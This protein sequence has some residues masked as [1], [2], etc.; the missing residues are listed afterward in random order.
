MARECGDGKTAEKLDTLYENRRQSFDGNGMM[1]ADSQYYEGN[2]WN[3]SF[4]L[5]HDMDARIELCGT[6]EEFAQR[7]DRFFGFT[8]GNDKTAR[9]EGYNNETDMETPY[10]YHYCGRRDRMCEVL[11]AGMKYMFTEG[12]GGIPGNNDSGA[13]SSC[14]VWNALGIFPVSGQ[15]LMLIGAP[16]IKKAVL[17]LWNGRDFTIINES[18]DVSTK[19]ELCGIPLPGMTL[20]VRQMM[21]GG[22]III[23]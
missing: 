4:R 13:L 12:R 14:F 11:R 2:L 5:M 17:H 20:T 1:R 16:I 15:D 8:D 3:Y 6:K 7:L 21:N 22:E 19:A 18:G 10:A 9:F 23:G